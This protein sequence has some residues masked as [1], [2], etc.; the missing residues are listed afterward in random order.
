M[1]EYKVD[2]QT[3]LKENLYCKECG[4]WV[5][6]PEMNGKKTNDRGEEIEYVG[7]GCVKRDEKGDFI[8]CPG[9][10]SHYYLQD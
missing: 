3:V 7:E 9:C 5:Y 8:E 4:E 2:L 6:C 1:G 10:G